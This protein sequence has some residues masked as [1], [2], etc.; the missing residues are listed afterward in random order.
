MIDRNRVA[1][2]KAAAPPSTRPRR[3][4]RSQRLSEIIADLKERIDAI[5]S[6]EVFDLEPFRTDVA[7]L[8]EAAHQLPRPVIDH[9]IANFVAHVSNDWD[10]VA[11]GKFVIPTTDK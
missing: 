3:E 7:R 4:S 2:L 1:E 11:G 9:D 8:S 5:P 10:L 6:G